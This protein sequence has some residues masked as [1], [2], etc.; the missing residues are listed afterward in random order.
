MIR[1]WS[2]AVLAMALAAGV[3]RGAEG[4][5]GAS[6]LAL[7][8]ECRAALGKSLIDFYLPGC[9]DSE[10][11]GY[12]EHL[13]DGVFTNQGE[14]F[15]V[16]QA[17]HLWFFSVMAGRGIETNRTLP[18]AGVGFEFLERWM[19]DREHGGY[20]SKVTDAGEPKDERKHGYLN[21]FAL[22]AM[23]AH[24]RAT[25]NR[26]AL[27]R[28]R[29]LFELLEAKAHDKEHG[30]YLEW[31]RRDWTPIVDPAEPSFVGASGRKTFNTHLH[32]LEAFAELHRAW[33]DPRVERRLR[34]LITILTST[35]LRHRHGASVDAFTPDWRVVEEPRNLRASHGHDIEAVWLVLDAADAIGLP[36]ATLRNWA[37]TL[38]ASCLER[39]YDAKHGGF[40]DG[41]PLGEASDA[42]NKTWWV[43]NEAAVGLLELHRFTG[44]ARYYEAFEKTLRF[45]LD[46]QIAAEGGWWATRA[47]DGSPTPDRTRTGPW[48]GAY[49]AG[50]ALLLCAEW[51]EE[52]AKK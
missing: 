28:A 21:A 16:L 39:G 13:K 35:I 50:R 52:M 37:E 3:C 44:E 14:K 41:G 11:G 34:E 46:H 45:Q 32:L 15:L 9:L 6:M 43:Q 29:E 49:H 22:Y 51:L 2:S 30:G 10:N 42:R 38:A 23:A 27:E 5:S 20:F 40:Y 12:N 25:G 26:L 1:I 48:Q 17:R 36:R 8:A 4:P 19:R 24:H 47:E 33:P 31:F 7:A 18:A